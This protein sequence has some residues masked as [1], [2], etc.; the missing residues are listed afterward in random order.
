MINWL[1]DEFTASGPFSPRPVAVPEWSVWA[2]LF[3]LFF[4]TWWCYRKG[5]QDGYRRGVGDAAALSE[6]GLLPHQQRAE[7]PTPLYDQDEGVPYD[8]DEDEDSY[9]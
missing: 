6:E 4:G 5:E 1:I 2:T 8:Q 9:W 7:T 3:A